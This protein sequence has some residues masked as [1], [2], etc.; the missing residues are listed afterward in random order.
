MS[1]ARAWPSWS[2]RSSSMMSMP[3]CWVIG[4]GPQTAGL[5][6]A[7]LGDPRFEWLGTVGEQEKRRRLRGADVLAAPSLHGE[8]FGVVLL[9]GMAA[10]TTVVASNISGYANVARASKDAFWCHRA[11]PPPWPPP[12]ARRWPA[13]RR[14]RPCA[15]R[16]RA[17][18]GALHG[19]AGPPLLGAVR[20]ALLAL[21][22]APAAG[23]AQQW[24]LEA[25]S[26]CAPRHPAW[27]PCPSAKMPRPA[28][29]GRWPRPVTA[30]VDSRYAPAA[31]RTRL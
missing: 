5:R 16:L 3:R 26:L 19:R 24:M 27:W 1:L 11:T 14:S 28:G 20:A 12:C 2:K 9:E 25:G 6:E 13:A 15:V 7:T 17:G 10:G 22:R 8:S 18:G 30:L 23:L 29:R 31:P 21:K 4:E